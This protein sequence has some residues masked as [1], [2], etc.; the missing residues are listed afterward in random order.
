MAAGEGSRRGRSWR[1]PP[2]SARG[3]VPD[4]SAGEGAREGGRRPAT[5]RALPKHLRHGALRIPQSLVEE[6][7][8]ESRPQHRATRLPRDPCSGSQEP[9]RG[10]GTKDAHNCRA[11]Q[12]CPGQPATGPTAASGGKEGAAAPAQ[13]EGRGGGA[14]A[15]PRSRSQ[16][17]PGQGGSA[18]RTRQAGRVLWSLL[19]LCFRSS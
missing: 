10:G 4:L 1:L 17:A 16:A 19:G 8:S 15:L 9:F 5:H 13:P 6:K 11:H 3:E 14:A 2:T 18:E 7:G 12:G